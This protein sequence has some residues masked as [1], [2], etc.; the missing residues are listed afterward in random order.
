VTVDNLG[1]EVLPHTPYS[2]ELAP[3][4]YHLFWPSEENAGWT[5][6]GIYKLVE[7]WDI[8]LNKLGYVEE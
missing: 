5:A 1:L 7:S 4:D 8:C 3:S 2:L 6:S